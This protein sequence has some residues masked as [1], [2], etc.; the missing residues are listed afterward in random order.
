MGDWHMYHCHGPLLAC[1]Y[2]P[3]LIIGVEMVSC[4][5]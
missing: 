4:R 1:M 5:H 2:E 3:Q